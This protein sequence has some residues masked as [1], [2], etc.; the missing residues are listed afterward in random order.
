MSK[1]VALSMHRFG[2]PKHSINRLMRSGVPM[3]HSTGSDTKFLYFA[4]LY[5]CMIMCD[6]RYGC[7][8]MLQIK[9]LWCKNITPLFK[10]V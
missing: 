8:S 4:T 5:V 9:K 10:L 6:D 3:Y 7:A 1:A 2:F